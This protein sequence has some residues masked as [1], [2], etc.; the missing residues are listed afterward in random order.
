MPIS[1]SGYGI[2]GLII[3]LFVLITSIVLSDPSSYATPLGLF[4]RLS[5]LYG[6]LM[7]AVAS[8]I[9]PYLVQVA[10]TFGKP[11]IRIH[12][13]FAALGIALVTVH[14]IS[15][16]LLV[17]TP[18]VF[19]PTF[20]TWIDFWANGGRIAFILLYIAAIGGLLRTRWKPWRYPHGLMYAVLLFAIVHANLIGTDFVHDGI[21]WFYNIVF[22]MVVVAFV[23]NI[24][25][26][27]R[28]RQK[29]TA[30]RKIGR[31]E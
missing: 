6:F 11:F 29:T 16:A 24:R 17:K 21:Q 4:V 1:R 5:A 22:A 27:W 14:P 3:L 23:L 26:K 31:P 7:T 8:V 20:Q 25:K 18:V 12:H 2:V 28:S 19:I 30:S 15:F 9:T 13:T 10:R